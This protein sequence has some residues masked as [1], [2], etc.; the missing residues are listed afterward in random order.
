MEVEITLE[1][2]MEVNATA[3]NNASRYFLVLSGVP[4][5]KTPLPPPDNPKEDEMI[6]PGYD[7]PRNITTEADYFTNYFSTWSGYCIAE[8][9]GYFTVRGSFVQ[10]V[11]PTRESLGVVTTVNNTVKFSF[12]L[13]KIFGNTIPDMIYFD[14]VTVDWPAAAPS[15]RRPLDHINSTDAYVSRASGSNKEIY[16]VDIAGSVT[17]RPALNIIKCAVT[18]Q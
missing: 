13:E 4:T 12:A 7:K 18:I 17:L 1:G 16:D 6:E 10:G 11:N 3:Q 8:S 14:V 2:T 9:G 15:L 5:L